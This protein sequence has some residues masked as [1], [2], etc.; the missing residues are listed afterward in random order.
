MAG[1]LALLTERLRPGKWYIV[2][3]GLGGAAAAMLGPEAREGA[4]ASRG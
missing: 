3:G 4:D 2:L 1:G